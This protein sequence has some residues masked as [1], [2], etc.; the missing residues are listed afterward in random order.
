VEGAAHDL[1]SGDYG[2]AAPN[3][4][5][6][7]AQIIASLKSRDGK[8]LIPGFYDR[9]LPPSAAETDAWSRLP[10]DPEEFRARE[11][12]SPALTGNPDSTC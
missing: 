6:A 10:F 11:V 12:G 2:G 4:V 9:V 8:V 1:H 7:V 3:A 5:E